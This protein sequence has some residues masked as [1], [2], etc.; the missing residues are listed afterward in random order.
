M[1]HRQWLTSFIKHTHAR[2]HT[3]TDTCTLPLPALF[4]YPLPVPCLPFAKLETKMFRCFLFS[5]SLSLLY[6]FLPSSPGPY[7]QHFLR[8]IPLP[9]P[10][11]SDIY[12]SL[13]F[14]LQI[15]P[16]YHCRKKAHC[17]PVYQ[18]ISCILS[19]FT[20]PFCFLCLSLTMLLKSIHAI[21]YFFLRLFLFIYL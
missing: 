20:C 8:R 7:L 14:H 5:L 10:I 3:L 1:T 2:S 9:A 21:T 17:V 12:L 18:H 6:H 19:S 15:A 16:L 4:P 11:I 13:S